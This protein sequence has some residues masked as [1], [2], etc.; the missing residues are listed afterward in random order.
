MVGT[1]YGVAAARGIPSAVNPVPSEIATVAF[2][3]QKC[4]ALEAAS[5][6]V[7]PL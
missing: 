4:V 7:V 2:D 5:V 6:I 1:I 3:A